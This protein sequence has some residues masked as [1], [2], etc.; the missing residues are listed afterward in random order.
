MS[1]ILSFAEYITKNDRVIAHNSG[2][3][4]ILLWKVEYNIKKE[5]I[6]PFY[7]NIGFDKI[8]SADIIT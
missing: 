6:C 2:V 7:W 4:A 3:L 8:K 5:E 1:I